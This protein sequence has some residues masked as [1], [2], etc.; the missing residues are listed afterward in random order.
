[1]IRAS[2]LYPFV[3]GARFD[4]DYYLGKHVPLTRSLLEP[5]GLLRLEV[6]RGLSAEEPGSAPRFVCVAHLYFA[7]P[8]AFQGAMR[9]HG[10]AL[11]ADVPNFTDL[12]LEIQVS[13]IVFSTASSFAGD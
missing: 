8:A 6:D 4:L 7:T 9:E 10:D 2:V 1:M 13:E 12:D 11:A 5:S 3:P